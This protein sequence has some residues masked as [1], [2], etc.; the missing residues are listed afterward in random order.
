MAKRLGEAR[1]K[2]SRPSVVRL[3]RATALVAMNIRVAVLV[4]PNRDTSLR[5]PRR[6]SRNSASLIPNRLGL[7]PTRPCVAATTG[8]TTTT[9]LVLVATP[10]CLKPLWDSRSGVERPGTVSLRVVSVAVVVDVSHE[11]SKPREESI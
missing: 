10:P 9:F 3:L 5:R 4:L 1:E 6:E 7:I 11:I 8:S 2:S